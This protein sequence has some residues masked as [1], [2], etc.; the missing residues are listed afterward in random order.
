MTRR[1]TEQTTDQ[2]LDGRSKGDPLRQQRRWRMPPGNWLVAVNWKKPMRPCCP[3][4]S[5]NLT[6][7]ISVEALRTSGLCGPAVELYRRE[8]EY[9]RAHALAASAAG[10]LAC[11]ATPSRWLDILDCRWRAL[12]YL[13]RW[14]R[15]VAD[16][17]RLREHGYHL[18]DDAG[19]CRILFFAMDQLAWFT[20][21]VP[22]QDAFERCRREVERAS[23]LHASLDN[24]FDRMDLLFE[25][26]LG[27]RRLR[28]ASD[29]PRAWVNL[30]PL[31]WTQNFAVVRPHLIPL[32]KQIG[33]APQAVLIALDHIA[34][35]SSAVASH[36]GAVLQHSRYEFGAF[37]RQQRPWDEVCNAARRFLAKFAGPYEQVRPDLLSFCLREALD[38]DRV[39]LA[40]DQMGILRDESGRSWADAISRDG[41]LRFVYA[42]WRAFWG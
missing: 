25:V 13:Q 18:Q 15:I 16:L 42:G 31:S 10:L 17:E 29:V 1:A 24:C 12:S 30:V 14:D 40:I 33:E 36:L 11:R 20:N 22:A 28:S 41:S 3:P 19:W 39:G 4:G 9:D 37:D 6:P 27:W 21:H 34:S 7:R 35:R 2:R 38:P 32:L 8:V 5:S 23:Y 26:V